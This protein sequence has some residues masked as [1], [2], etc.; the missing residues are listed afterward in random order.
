LLQK[1][2][3]VSER[4]AEGVALEGDEVTKYVDLLDCKGTSRKGRK[5]K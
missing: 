3:F 2:H 4:K 5:F 1:S